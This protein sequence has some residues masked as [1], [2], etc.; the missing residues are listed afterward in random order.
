MT[1]KTPSELRRSLQTIIASAGGDAKDVHV[2]ET[3]RGLAVRSHQVGDTHI[4][5]VGPETGSARSSE[6][7]PAE[8]SAELAIG[9]NEIAVHG[10]IL[11][12]RGQLLLMMTA[13]FDM[14]LMVPT[15]YVE[16]SEIL[17]DI[18]QADNKEVTLRGFLTARGFIVTELVEGEDLRK[19]RIA[20]YV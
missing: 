17:Y 8:V 12:I 20:D 4:L 15:E 2:P 13:G 11:S 7:S 5:L 9:I 6:I 3:K 16:Y 19:R 10:E 18:S 1:K 14:L